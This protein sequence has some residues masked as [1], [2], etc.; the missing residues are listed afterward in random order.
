MTKED[1]DFL[2]ILGF[3]KKN[4]MHLAKFSLIFWL[5]I[6]SKKLLIVFWDMH[7]TGSPR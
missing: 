4:Q 2:L 5:Q 6:N 1:F 3:L 7:R